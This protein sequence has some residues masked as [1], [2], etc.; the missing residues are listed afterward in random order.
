MDGQQVERRHSLQ[1]ELNR[2]IMWTAFAFAMLASLISGTIAFYE[3][4]EEQD[5][6]LRQIARLVRIDQLTDTGIHLQDEDDEP[7]I[8]QRLDGKNPGAPPLIPY[9]INDGLETREINGEE[10]RVLALTLP[11]STQRFAIAQ[12]T[13]AR[14]ELAWDSS[15]SVFLPIMLLVAIMLPIINYIIRSRFRSLKSLSVYLDQQ[16]GT[17]LKALSETGISEEIAPFILSINGLLGRIRQVLQKQ[18]RFIADAAHEL[19]TPVAAL[20]LLAENLRQATSEA[21]FH[22]RQDFL[23]EGLERLRILVSQL[24]DLARLQSEHISP[25]EKVSFFHIVQ[26]VIADLYPLAEAGQ[27]D[28][29]MARQEMLTVLDQGRELNQ[30]IRN[31]ID[32]AIRYTPAGG[33]VD[34]SMFAQAGKAVFCVEDTGIGIPEEELEQVMEPFYRAQRITQPGNGLGLAISLEI[35]HRLGGTIELSNRPEGGLQFLYKQPLIQTGNAQLTP[36]PA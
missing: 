20:S 35:A 23:Q 19:R 13:E 17:R 2:W 12:Q 1:Q 14:D 5:N 31:A 16:D 8:I 27:I 26:D 6:M 24:L 4:R 21:D 10:W 28:L 29:G 32:N 18:Q 33:K 36:N 9:D 22:E 11:S 34:V 3:A 7:I 15:F 30:L 25:A